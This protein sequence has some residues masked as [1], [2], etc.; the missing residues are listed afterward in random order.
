MFHLIYY[1]S[2]QF[3]N[4]FKSSLMQRDVHFVNYGLIYSKTDD[5][6][7][8]ALG[9]GYHAIDKLQSQCVLWF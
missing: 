1:L 8:Y 7:G 5:K 9:W 2:E 6:A 4:G 3:L